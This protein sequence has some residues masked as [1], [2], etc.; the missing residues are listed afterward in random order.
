MITR[1]H[2]YF[3]NCQ[4]SPKLTGIPGTGYYGSSTVVYDEL[5]GTWYQV[6]G[7]VVMWMVNLAINITRYYCLMIRQTG[8]VRP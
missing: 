3:H 6:P 5:P 4:A 2:C 7:T 1:L 8:E